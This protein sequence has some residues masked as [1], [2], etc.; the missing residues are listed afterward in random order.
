MPTIL[1]KCVLYARVSPQKDLDAKTGTIEAQL[2]LCRSYAYR[3]GL[4]VVAEHHDLGKSGAAPFEKRPGLRAALTTA[5]NEPA[6]LLSYSLSRIA[7]ST[8]E[9]GRIVRVLE[10]AGA[11]LACVKENI[12]T[13][14]PFGRFYL[15][16]LVALAELERE[17]IRERTSDALQ[18]RK[19]QGK[20]ISREPRY[21]YCENPKRPGYE[22]VCE[23]EQK[24]MDYMEELV[25]TD[26]TLQQVCDRLYDEGIVNRYGNKWTTKRLRKVLTDSGRYHPNPRIVEA[27]RRREA[28]KAIT[29]RG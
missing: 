14:T 12:D 23:R 25:N 9:A 27:A 22:M 11:K 3:H 6:V 13:N 19:S 10:R 24:I 7:R 18:A 8:I 15:Q 28:R 2:E 16:M 26:L 17:Q 29:R 20:I 21:G 4:Y 1:T 5:A